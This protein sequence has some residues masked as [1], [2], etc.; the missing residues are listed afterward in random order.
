M[1]FLKPN[2]PFVPGFTSPLNV[3]GMKNDKPHMS[4]SGP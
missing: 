4:A 3:F 2:A 1:H